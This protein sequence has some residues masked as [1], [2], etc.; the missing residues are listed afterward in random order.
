MW[1]GWIELLSGDEPLIVLKIVSCFLAVCFKLVM[2]T[3]NYNY[4]HFFRFLAVLEYSLIDVKFPPTIAAHPV[5][6]KEH[7]FSSNFCF[8]S[9]KTLK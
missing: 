7:F 6:W 3:S 1:Y 2:T 4:T 8:E 5:H 9:F